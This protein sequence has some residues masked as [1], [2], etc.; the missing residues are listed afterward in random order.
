MLTLWKKALT[1][2][3]LHQNDIL[4]EKILGYLLLSFNFRFL[5]YLGREIFTMPEISKFLE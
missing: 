5:R 1:R 2:V 4:I 3:V